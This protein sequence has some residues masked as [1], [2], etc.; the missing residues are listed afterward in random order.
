MEIINKNTSQEN[1]S[2]YS[3]CDHLKDL[4]LNS[5]INSQ[6]FNYHNN[7]ISNYVIIFFK[8]QL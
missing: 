1:T 5:S 6:G 8:Q 3:F 2:K 4:Y 7:L